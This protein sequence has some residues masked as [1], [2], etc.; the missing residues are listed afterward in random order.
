M[1]VT[2]ATEV[3][4]TQEGAVAK[5][6]VRDEAGKFLGATNQ[7]KA[8]PAKKIVRPRVIIQGR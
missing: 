7:T 6:V 2:V 8:L 5:A 1:K 4:N 3:W